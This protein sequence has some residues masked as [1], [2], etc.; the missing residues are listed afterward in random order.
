MKT[1]FFF[2][3]T[4]TTVILVSCNNS[5]TQSVSTYDIENEDSK[6]LPILLEVGDFNTT[7]WEKGYSTITQKNYE[8]ENLVEKASFKLVAKHKP[9][10][11]FYSITHSLSLYKNS[12]VLSLEDLYIFEQNPIKIS[13]LIIE[14][15]SFDQAK[16][17][18]MNDTGYQECIF[19]KK[20]GN[21]VSSISV[22]V[23]EYIEVKKIIE[24]TLPFLKRIDSK[25]LEI[26]P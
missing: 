15:S 22:V 9:D 4:L 3:V 13:R 21:L 8:N 14:D 17:A 11:D 2:L 12:T 18:I 7:N 5:N 26:L 10:R 6:L 25:V 19:M 1:T 16:C 23:K 20:Y 24:W